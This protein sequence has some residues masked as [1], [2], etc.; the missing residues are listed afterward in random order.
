MVVEGRVLT[1][2]RYALVRDQRVRSAHHCL[3]VQIAPGP[4]NVSDCL[5]IYSEITMM[6]GGEERLVKWLIQAV[7]GSF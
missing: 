1:S 2:L 4:I 3:Q 5:T 7:S 6:T